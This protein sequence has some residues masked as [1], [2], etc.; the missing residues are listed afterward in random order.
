MCGGIS[1]IAIRNGKAKNKYMKKFD[2]NE[3]SKYITYLS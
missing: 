3:P 2:I 1:Y